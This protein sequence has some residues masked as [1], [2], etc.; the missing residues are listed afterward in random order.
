[1]Q[2]VLMCHSLKL[3]RFMLT[4]CF[5]DQHTEVCMPVINYS[6]LFKDGL[7]RCLMKAR[8]LEK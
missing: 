4:P 8:G 6:Q 1:M 2:L 3:I 7:L 5:G